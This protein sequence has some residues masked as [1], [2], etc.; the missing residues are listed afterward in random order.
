MSFLVLE[1]LVIIVRHHKV[2]HSPIRS[3]TIHGK[4][5]VQGGLDTT[6]LLSRDVVGPSREIFL[7][8]QPPDT[9]DIGVEKEEQRIVCGDLET[10][11]LAPNTCMHCSVLLTV[12]IKSSEDIDQRLTIPPSKAGAKVWKTVLLQDTVSDRN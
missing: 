2:P 1:A 11:H 9:V 12:S 3:K 10:T 5:I 4:D 7:L 6:F 8:P